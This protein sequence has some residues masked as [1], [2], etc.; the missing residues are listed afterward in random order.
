MFDRQGTAMGDAVAFAVDFLGGQVDR[1]QAIL[2]CS[3]GDDPKPEQ[4]TWQAAADA[5]IQVYGLFLGDEERTATII[6]GREQEVSSSR[7]TLN[8]LAQTTGS[9]ALNTSIDDEDMLILMTT[10]HNTSRHDHGKKKN[11]S[12]PVSVTIGFVVIGLVVLPYHYRWALHAASNNM[13]RRC[14]D[15]S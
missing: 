4:V 5:A 6:D 8:T 15:V 3:D 2:I 9:I 13:R 12:S 14:P 11:A 10:C 1:G 7:Q